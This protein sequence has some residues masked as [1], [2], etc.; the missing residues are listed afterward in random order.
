LG[1]HARKPGIHVIKWAVHDIWEVLA[2]KEKNWYGKE[3]G[4]EVVYP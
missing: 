2:E 3:S 1:I 4:K